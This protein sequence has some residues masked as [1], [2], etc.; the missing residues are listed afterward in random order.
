MTPTAPAPAPF[1]GTGSAASRRIR[2][3]RPTRV[4]A[5]AA[6]RAIGW[7]WEDE[8]QPGGALAP[9]LTVFLAGA[10]CVFTCTHCDMWRHTL[11]GPTPPG[12]LPAQL[13]SALA[14]A[15]P[16][17]AGARLKVY[18]ASNFFDERAVPAADEPALLA[19]AEP[20]TEVVVECHPRL[21]GERCF[22][23]AAQLAE[24][25]GRLQVAL[26]L[27]TA[28]PAA[29]ARLNKRMTVAGFRTAA[30]ALA[31]HGIGVRSFVLVGV[32]GVPAAEAAASAASS[33]AVAVDAGAE[34]VALIPLRPGNGA[35]DR[36]VAD[37]ELE[38]PG[39]GDLED[40]LDAALVDHAA[41]APAV[42]TADLWDLE[43]LAECAA[44]FDARR[45]RLERLN[46]H[47]RP[48]PRIGCAECGGR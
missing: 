44:C 21:V 28:E 40:A 34:H 2:A 13:E 30:A 14:A 11:D 35:V 42:V 5:V 9:T 41:A 24:R 33:A 43:R 8:R 20:F 45:R 1:P 23:F 46:L 29:L 36:L 19:L 37:G 26:G 17:P 7:Q 4:E 16:A 22:A 48:L 10:E 27:E 15:G 18:N 47:G 31:E 3:L 32:P 38:L 6:D 12:A 39:L 25:G